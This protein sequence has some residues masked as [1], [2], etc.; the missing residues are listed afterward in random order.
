MFIITGNRLTEFLVLATL[1]L[2]NA[3]MFVNEKECNV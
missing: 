2:I 3:A 1:Y